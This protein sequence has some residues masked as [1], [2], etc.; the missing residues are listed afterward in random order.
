MS[1]PALSGLGLGT[2]GHPSS[3]PK[4]QMG[5]KTVSSWQQVGMKEQQST[6]NP[7]Q[8]SMSRQ[9]QVIVAVTVTFQDAWPHQP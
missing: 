2:A 9:N 3:F 7:A 4:G 1:T 6:Q 8:C 5:T